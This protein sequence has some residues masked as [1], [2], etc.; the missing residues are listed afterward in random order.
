VSGCGE[1][2]PGF[3][4]QVATAGHKDGHGCKSASSELFAVSRP[5]LHVNGRALS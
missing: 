3:G 5:G 4:A 2:Q 1:P